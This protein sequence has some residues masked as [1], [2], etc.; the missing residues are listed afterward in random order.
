MPGNL[1]WPATNFAIPPGG[2]A[3]IA[4]PAAADLG[5]AIDVVQT[6]AI[7]LVASQPVN[8]YGLNHIRF[9]TDAYLGLSTKALGRSYREMDIN[10]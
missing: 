3:T 10:F 5:N 4:L 9:T 8:V 7:H 6:N 2:V 1:G